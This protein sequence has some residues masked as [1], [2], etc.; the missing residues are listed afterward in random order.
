M[1]ALESGRGTGRV[2]HDHDYEHEHEEPAG[3][4]VMLSSV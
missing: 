2:E 3:V 4:V 1:S